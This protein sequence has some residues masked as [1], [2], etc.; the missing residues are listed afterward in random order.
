[1]NKI[2]GFNRNLMNGKRPHRGIQ[3]F[4]N[5]PKAITNLSERFKLETLWLNQYLK[6]VK[7]LK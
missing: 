5:Y 2:K 1:M 6:R 7:K 4:Q 3:R